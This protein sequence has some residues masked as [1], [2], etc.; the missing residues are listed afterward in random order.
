MARVQ[1]MVTK[2]GVLVL[3]NASTHTINVRVS[4]LDAYWRH[5]DALS[6]AIQVARGHGRLHGNAYLEKWWLVE[7]LVCIEDGAHHDVL[8]V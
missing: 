8:H 1:P 2:V 7:V 6:R 5:R 4:D 3:A